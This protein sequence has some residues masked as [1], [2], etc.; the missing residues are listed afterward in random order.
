MDIDR[1]KEAFR[2]PSDTFS[3]SPEPAVTAAVAALNNAF[4]LSSAPMMGSGSSGGD[5][6]AAMNSLVLSNYLNTKRLSQ[7]SS[8]TRPDMLCG[9]FG[10]NAWKQ[11]NSDGKEQNA[12]KNADGV[13]SMDK[14]LSSIVMAMA[15]S[16]KTPNFL[17]NVFNK[18]ESNGANGYLHHFSNRY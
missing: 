5:A 8:V 3:S 16:T 4:Q 17:S 7:D 13:G 9:T 18:S 6:G 14:R 11:L 12:T 15:A 2:P 10:A 1:R